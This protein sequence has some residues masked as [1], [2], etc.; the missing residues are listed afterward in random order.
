M[1]AGSWVGGRARGVHCRT[2]PSVVPSR[3]WPRICRGWGR[4]VAGVLVGSAGSVVLVSAVLL[5]SAGHRAAAANVHPAG[6]G[7]SGAHGLLVLLQERPRIFPAG[8]KLP[9]AGGAGPAEEPVTARR[10]LLP[11]IACIVLT[12]CATPNAP[13]RAKP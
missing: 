7:A 12:A 8:P 1:A 3:R 10:T 9:G 2:E 5:P 6:P 4:G 13:A 11:I